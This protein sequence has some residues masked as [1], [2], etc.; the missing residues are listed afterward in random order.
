MSDSSKKR[1]EALLREQ[2]ETLRQSALRPHI[3][4][5]LYETHSV[6]SSENEDMIKA[7]IEDANKYAEAKHIELFK[8]KRRLEQMAEQEGM[9]LEQM[10]KLQAMS[11]SSSKGRMLK[12]EEFILKVI[13]IHIKLQYL[14]SN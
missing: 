5:V 12:A 9:T 1:C 4:Y 13:T 6:V 2:K 8:E 3:Q 10:E 14:W 11:P 7:I